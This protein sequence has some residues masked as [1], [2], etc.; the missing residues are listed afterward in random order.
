[1]TDKEKEIL[2]QAKAIKQK[3]VTRLRKQKYKGLFSK[4]V[5]FLIFAYLF[6]F[7]ERILDIFLATSQEP[8]VLIGAVFGILGLECGVMGWIKSTK[9]KKGDS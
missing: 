3:E 9:I 7:T 5:L 6:Y 8:I 2:E 1:M 4:I